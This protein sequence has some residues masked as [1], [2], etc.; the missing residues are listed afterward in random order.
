VRV[1]SA[2]TEAESY[3]TTS[4]RITGG[5]ALFIGLVCLIDIVVEWRTRTGLITAALIA[6]VMVLAYVGLI[7]PSMTLSPDRL[8]VHNHL[9][10]H[11]VPWADVEGT[12]VADVLRVQLPGRRLRCPG[13]QLMM[14]DLRKQRYGRLKTEDENTLTRAGFVVSRIEHHIDHYAKSS[15]GEVV[16]RWAKPEL[17]TAGVLALIAVVAWLAG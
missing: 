9:R 6:L 4:S 8:R 14:R 15:T 13:V 16:T 17:I 7:R 2:P 3:S 10:D 1:K 12:D 5:I 11:E